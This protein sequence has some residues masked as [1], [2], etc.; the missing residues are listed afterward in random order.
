MQNDLHGFGGTETVE[1]ATNMNSQPVRGLKEGV[2]CFVRFIYRQDA[3]DCYQVSRTVGVRYI[4]TDRRCSSSIFIIAGA[5]SGQIIFRL[6]DSFLVL[7]HLR[8]TLCQSLLGGLIL[9]GLPS[10]SSCRD[11]G[12]TETLSNMA[13]SI[14][15]VGNRR[16]PTD[17]RLTDW[18]NSHPRSICIYK[19]HHGRGSYSCDSRRSEGPCMLSMRFYC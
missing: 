4:V 9:E 18:M 6:L 15:Q 17:F 10:W 2:R 5:H 7:R 11:L 12:G 3:V 19:V 1:F 8:S 13:S 16:L 14:N